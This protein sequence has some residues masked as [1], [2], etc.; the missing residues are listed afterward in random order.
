MTNGKK[1]DAEKI[2]AK[3]SQERRK[4][5]KSKS[6]RVKTREEKTKV[7]VDTVWKFDNVEKDGQAESQKDSLP[8]RRLTLI[9]MHFSPMARMARAALTEHQSNSTELPMR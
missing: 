9:M 7:N 5:K 1:M 2:D 3:D 6:R 8:D 4:K